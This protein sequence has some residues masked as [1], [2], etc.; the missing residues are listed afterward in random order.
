MDELLSAH[1]PFPALIDI[2]NFKSI[3]DTGH[4]SGDIVLRNVAREGIQIM[5][6]HNVSVYR[7][8]GEEF[9]VIFR[10]DQ[11]A[12][13]FSLLDAWRTAVENASGGKKPAGNVQCWS[14][15]MAFRTA[16]GAGGERR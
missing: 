15:R 12:S 5:Q 7:Y 9:A 13:A 10:A 6:P 1:Q 16:G 2:D 4:L 3:N 8:G 11:I 14:G